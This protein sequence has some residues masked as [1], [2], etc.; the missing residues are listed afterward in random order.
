[1]AV[2]AAHPAPLQRL[3]ALRRHRRQ[4]GKLRRG[5]APAVA[6]PRHHPLQP[7]PPRRAAAT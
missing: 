6:R 1:V 5:Q 7:R 3:P 2:V 4:P